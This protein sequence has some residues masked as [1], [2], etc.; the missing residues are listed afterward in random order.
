MNSTVWFGNKDELF[1][2]KVF[3]LQPSFTDPDIVILPDVSICQ[4]RTR[5]TL[6]GLL[7]KQEVK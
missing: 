3:T 6:Y 1:T 5:L 4:Y 2:S 7:W